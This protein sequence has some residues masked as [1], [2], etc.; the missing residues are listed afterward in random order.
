MTDWQ[1]DAVP[2]TLNQEEAHSWDVVWKAPF[3][4]P[5]PMEK[6]PE[7]WEIKILST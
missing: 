4:G 7:T 2:S 1:G 5:R 6:R 3:K